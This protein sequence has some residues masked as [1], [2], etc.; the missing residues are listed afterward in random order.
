MFKIS[1]R[2]YFSANSCK[3]LPNSRKHLQNSR[4]RLQNSRKPLQ[5]VVRRGGKVWFKSFTIDAS[6]HMAIVPL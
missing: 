1:L 2:I 6:D 5:T 3:R 4:K